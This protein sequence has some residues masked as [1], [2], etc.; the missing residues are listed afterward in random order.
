MQKRG[1][2]ALTK[3]KGSAYESAQ[4]S[5]SCLEIVKID[6]IKLTITTFGSFIA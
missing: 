6:M 3:N 5:F 2:K 4:E 1:P